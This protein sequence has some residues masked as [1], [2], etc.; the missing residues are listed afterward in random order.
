MGDLK[1]LDRLGVDSGT[2]F[3]RFDSI[4][5]NILSHDVEQLEDQIPRDGM[6]HGHSP[7]VDNYLEDDM[8]A[9][10]RYRYQ[11]PVRNTSNT[12][13]TDRKMAP[14][15]SLIG[16]STIGNSITNIR[17]TPS[18]TSRRTV[19][20]QPKLDETSSFRESLGAYQSKDDFG[21]VFWLYA[22]IMLVFLIT[23]IL[24]LI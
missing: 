14:P 15:N 6:Y 5:P 16:S 21:V 7:I 9:D 12:I 19:E 18:E 23:I 8:G 20:D 17:R 10:S 11:L 4:P 22:S 3:G 24:S 1:S 2:Q 13:E